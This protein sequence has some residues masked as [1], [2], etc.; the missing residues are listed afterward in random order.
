MEGDFFKRGV[1]KAVFQG[2]GR[3]EQ[4]SLRSKI[5]FKGRQIEE[6]V[7]PGIGGRGRASKGVED[8]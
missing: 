6:A 5:S 4:E 1:T 7:V 8:G 2:E 3:E